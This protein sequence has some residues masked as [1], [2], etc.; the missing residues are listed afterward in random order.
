VLA[1]DTTKLVVNS[2][3]PL[4]VPAALQVKDWFVFV[5]GVERETPFLI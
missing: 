3:L 2:V 1:L 5:C 4:H